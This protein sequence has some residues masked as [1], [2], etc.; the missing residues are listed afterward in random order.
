MLPNSQSSPTSDDIEA[1]LFYCLVHGIFPVASFTKIPQFVSSFQ[2]NATYTNVTTG[3][4]L[5]LVLTNGS[6]PH[7]VSGLRT[8]S[9]ITTADV[10]VNGG[11]MQLIDTV[12]N[13]PPREP[14]VVQ[15]ANLNFFVALVTKGGFLDANRDEFATQMEYLPDVT[16]FAPNSALALANFPSSD[17]MSPE[18]LTSIFDYHVVTGFIGYSSMLS[19]K[20]TLQTVEGDNLTIRIGS[21]GSKWVNGAKIITSDFMISNGVLHTI[22]DFL[23]PQ[24]VTSPSWSKSHKPLQPGAIAGLIVGLILLLTCSTF[25]AFL[26]FHR[27]GSQSQG[28]IR[29]GRNNHM[30]MRPGMSLTQLWKRT[31]ATSSPLLS[32]S[33]SRSQGRSDSEPEWGGGMSEPT[34]SPDHFETVAINSGQIAE[35]DVARTRTRSWSLPIQELSGSEPRSLS[36]KE[37]EAWERYPAERYQNR[38]VYD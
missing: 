15:Q 32:R 19:D 24:N 20:L 28:Q 22:D 16:Y 26:F 36:E 37:E 1:T 30:R 23:D 10:V 31:P 2:E 7:I 8:N 17:T 38:H 34:N 11:I 9:S 18:R 21:D 14:I 6:V 5:E 13:L 12:P 35:L 25:L 27:T 29:L 4:T 33:A 3:Q